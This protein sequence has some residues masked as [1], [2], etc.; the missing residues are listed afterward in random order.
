MA[1]YVKPLPTINAETAPFW[2]AAK[3]HKLVIQKCKR[4][5]NL[6]HFPRAI[7]GACGNEE[8]EWV[9]SSGKGEVYSLTRVYMNRAPG[10]VD[11]VPYVFAI[12]QLN[13]GIHM[14]SNV[15]GTPAE[16]VVIGTPV[17]VIF[18]DVN[19]EVSIPKFKVAQ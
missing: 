14:I 12:I 19:D 2:A 18:E 9:Q 4:C 3:E 16:E 1:D 10:W 17:E 13:E 7:C 5:W 11:E 6:Q 15:V 8:F